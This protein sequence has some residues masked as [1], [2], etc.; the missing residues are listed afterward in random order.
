VATD[1]H[2]ECID[3]TPVIGGCQFAVFVVFVVF[4]VAVFVVVH[5]VSPLVFFEQTHGV[6]QRDV[7]K[8]AGV[9]PVE[10]VRD[11][12]VTEGQTHTLGSCRPWRSAR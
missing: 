2:D 9:L 1:R 8:T 12:W 5:A 6:A 3:V 4:V 11:R 10:W 7:R